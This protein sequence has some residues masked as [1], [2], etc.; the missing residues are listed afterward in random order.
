[1]AHVRLA[2]LLGLGAERREARW[3]FAESAWAHLFAPPRFLD[4]AHWLW[5]VSTCLLVLQF[6]TPMR[7]HWY[8]ARHISAQTEP[9]WYWS[10]AVHAVAAL[11]YAVLMGFA[12]TLSV[13]TS[14]VLMIM[15]L[16][17]KLP[18]PRIDQAVHWVVV[19][20]SAVLGDTYVLAHC[21]VQFAAMRTK[22]ARDL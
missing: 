15:A 18:I 4:L 20:L 1:P 10:A 9:P 19:R 17:A 3:L 16:A 6:I 7:R 2:V 5:K 22:V 11:S 21:P 14:L 12:A 13:L 8:Q